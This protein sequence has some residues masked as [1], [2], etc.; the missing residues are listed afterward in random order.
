[1]RAV[2][3]V[4]AH[5]LPQEFAVCIGRFPASQYR[6]MRIRDISVGQWPHDRHSAADRR[7]FQKKYYSVSGIAQSLG[8]V[9]SRKNRL[10]DVVGGNMVESP[11]CVAMSP[12][13]GL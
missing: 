8:H 6:S 1:M 5:C 10:L 7:P 2:P 9:G 13:R 4:E 3:I 11:E 12:G